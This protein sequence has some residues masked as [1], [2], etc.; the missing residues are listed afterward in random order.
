MTAVQNR[1]T[2][3]SWIDHARG[4]AVIAMVVFHFTFDLMFF[5]YI[6]QG[7]VYRLEWRLFESAI[8]GSFLFLA[9][10]SFM[11][12]HGKS[13]RIASL[14]RKVLLLAVAAAGISIV[15]YFIF[16]Q[17]MIRVG[18]LHAILM[19]MIGAIVLRHLHWAALLGMAIAIV[20]AFF[21]VPIPVE[22]PAWLQWAIVTTS[23][24]FSVDYR[25][26]VPWSAAFLLGMA[27]SYALSAP[28]P[29]AHRFTW[30]TF[31]GQ[32][33]LIIYLVHQPILFGIFNVAMWLD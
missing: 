24:P 9:G 10:V 3:Y 7:T 30:L 23:T 11:L 4:I 18:I 21:T 15:T 26:L 5:G 25:P 32:N 8:A 12:A 22:A 20:T 17:N 28:N 13:L 29:K 31:L 14:R 1:P 16:G 19:C 27:A 2:R 6:A 33:S